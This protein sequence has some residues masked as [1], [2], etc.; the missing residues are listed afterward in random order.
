MITTMTDNTQT[1]TA[2]VSNYHGTPRK[3]RLLADFSRGKDAR[4]VLAELEFVNKR[5]AQ[6]LA[7]VIA[8][9]VANA[10]DRSINIDGWIIADIQ[11]Q[12]GKSMKRQRAGSRGRALVF[13]RRLSHI[14]VTLGPKPVKEV[15][16]D[17]A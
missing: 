17:K 3:L 11:V 8:S 12:E 6:G 4:K 10:Q 1:V 15:T 16:A 9:A 2:S 14:S 5:H 7:K 13:R